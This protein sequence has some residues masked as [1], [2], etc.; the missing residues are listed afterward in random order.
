[1]IKFI[2]KLFKTNINKEDKK[3]YK[4]V[5]ESKRI[6]EILKDFN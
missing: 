1:M 5:Q 2:K 4:K 6:E 3:E